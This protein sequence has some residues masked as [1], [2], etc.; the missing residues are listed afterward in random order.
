MRVPMGR[1]SFLS[2]VRWPEKR[3]ESDAILFGGDTHRRYP[4]LMI[5]K[6]GVAKDVSDGSDG[7]PIVSDL[8]PSCLV[9]G[10]AGILKSWNS[11]YG[12]PWRKK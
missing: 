7:H 1:T 8:D 5:G 2:L 10:T 12:L 6:P 11:Q 3:R 9:H 4:N